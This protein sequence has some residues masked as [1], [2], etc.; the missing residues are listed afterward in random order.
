ML[1]NLR[2]LF[3]CLKRNNVKYVVIG[4][5]AAIFHGV[6]RAT[7]DLDLFIE[8]TDINAGRLLEALKEANFGT[9]DMTDAIDIVSHP[10]TIF[11]DKIKVDC[12]T[13]IPGLEFKKAWGNKLVEYYK[14]VPLNV[15]SKDDLL[16]AKQASK[17]KIDKEDIKI[18]SKKDKEK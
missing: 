16:K 5:I 1:S 15:I 14:E 12:F 2:E 18:L 11:N 17:R 7:F 4:G 8:K 3:T 9:A 6:P 10:I 13:T